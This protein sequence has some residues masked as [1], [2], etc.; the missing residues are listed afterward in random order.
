MSKSVLQEEKVCIICG[1]TWSLE[2]HHIFRTP[3]RNKSEKYG[4]KV[5]LCHNHHT[6]NEGVHNGNVV[7]DKRL[8]QMAQKKFEE[9]FGREKFIREFGRNYL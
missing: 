9:K 8:K 5:W 6:G 7:I 4:L 2:E 1:T 3:Y